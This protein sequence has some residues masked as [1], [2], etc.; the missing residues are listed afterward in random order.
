MVEE[1]VSR[2]SPSS[3]L[4]AGEPTAAKPQPLAEVDAT[5]SRP[6]PTGVGEFDRVL[7]GGLVPGSVT[8][9]GGEP[10][11]GK[12]TLLLQ[13]LSGFAARGGRGLLVS[14]EEG[15]EQVSRRAS[16]LG[17][18]TDGT[19]LIAE[20]DL[21]SIAAA[22]KETRPDLL[23]VDSIQTIRDGEQEAGAGS[24]SQVRSCAQAFVDLAKETGVATIL[25]GHVTKDGSLAGPRVLEHVVDTV[26]SFEGER[27]HSLRLLRATKHRFGAVGELGVFEM[28]EQGLAGV[29]DAG[30]M[31]LN[32]RH[33]DEPGSVVFPA[34]E[35]QRPLLVEM[36]ALVAPSAL[37]NPR[38]SASGLDNSRLS[39]LLA[40]LDRRLDH[41]TYLQ[42][43]YVSVAG[44]VK[45]T[46]PGADLAMCLA[47]VSSISNRPV[48]RDLVAVGEIGLAGELRQVGHAP[49][50]LAEAARLGFR[51]A[52]VPASV[53]AD[54]PLEV[55][56][57][58]SLRDA[59]RVAFGAE[60]AGPASP[61]AD[62]HP[63]PPAPRPSGAY[64]QDPNPRG[65][66]HPGAKTPR[67]ENPGRFHIVRP[68]E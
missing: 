66:G 32:D 53:T 36:Q 16:R 60:I 21:G 25:V 34:M 35:G 62:T 14:A 3:R 48:P 6:R 12:S 47:L 10:G 42:D 28:G 64:H 19:W 40:V 57:V 45:V 37:A 4:G 59:L 26:L 51:R 24:V 43:V 2:P 61:L 49:R 50:R 13:A 8:L 54:A 5:G 63:R 52:L 23:V 44:G 18:T 58:S 27:Y 46:E 31:F 56:R 68:G 9:L 1:A 29:A 41:K 17:A 20:S 22:V 55:I 65:S 15:P 33:E 67:G 11:I 30:G 7:G 39:L 38:R